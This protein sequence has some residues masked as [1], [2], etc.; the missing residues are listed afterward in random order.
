MGEDEFTA[1]YRELSGHVFSF[2]A[3]RLSPQAADDAVALTF[4][5]VWDK[6]AECPTDARARIGWVFVIARFKV[7]QEADRQHRKH[8]D[9]RFVSDFGPRP[10]SEP[11][12]SD[13]VVESAAGRWIFQQLSAVE[14]DLFDVAFM[15]GVNREDG[16][17]MMAV[18]VGTFATRVS[19]LRTRI[20]ALQGQSDG[21]DFSA[22][23]GVS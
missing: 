12:V 23:S 20:K 10:A 16:A 18:S 13:S 22:E 6:R 8:H 3:R 19:R 4:E 9:H 11:D 21:I 17:A 15:S 7:L 5:T 14:R 1:L 2:A